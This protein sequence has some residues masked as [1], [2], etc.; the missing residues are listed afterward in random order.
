MSSN[1]F[2]NLKNVNYNLPIKTED[3]TDKIINNK[4]VIDNEHHPSDSLLHNKFNNNNN[5]KTSHFIYRRKRKFKE[6]NSS[7]DTKDTKN[8]KDYKELHSLLNYKKMK[9][10]SKLE[11][12][13]SN[14]KD[15]ENNKIK[16]NN[17]SVDF[18]CEPLKD[19]SLV[20]G[21]VGEANTNTVKFNKFVTDSSFNVKHLIFHE[22]HEN[23]D[24][25]TS[26]NILTLTSGHGHLINNNNNI[27]NNQLKNNDQINGVPNETIKDINYL[28]TTKLTT[29]NKK[30][31]K[32]NA[33]SIK[34]R[35]LKPILYSN[36]NNTKAL[37][38]P[39]T[40]LNN[41]FNKINTS[42]NVTK[43][44]T[45]KPFTNANNLISLKDKENKG[46]E[47]NLNFKKKVVPVNDAKII[48]EFS[49]IFIKPEA[50]ILTNNTNNLK[51][52]NDSDSN[53]ISN[54]IYANNNTISNAI[55]QESAEP[56]EA[57]EQKED[58]TLKLQIKSIIIPE[59]KP[60]NSNNNN[61]NLYTHTTNYNLNN[62]SH[63]Q[64]TNHQTFNETTTRPN[65]NFINANKLL[66]KNFLQSKHNFINKNKAKKNNDDLDNFNIH[67]GFN[68][69]STICNT[70]FKARPVPSYI[71]REVKRSNRDLTIP[72][73]PNITKSKKYQ[74]N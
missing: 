33:T 24:K 30:R 12:S 59:V 46:K 27:I 39:H 55:K 61:N 35:N 41:R 50:N 17:T 69:Y 37:K 70:T 73:S 22:K 52:N 51:I 18:K 56:K 9:V 64:T 1:Q 23:N 7:K 5:D 13:L 6:L 57:H 68:N 42:K 31:I 58:S 8:T 40:K 2:L 71:F 53:G 67:Y 26:K 29:T 60:T 21:T 65:K 36:Y 43:S 63:Q 3:I 62:I 38:T 25:I 15:K 74:K 45:V 54:T 44:A 49:T 11:H 28:Q 10:K 20:V 14:S 16:T 19:N 47:L 66:I 4:M 48:K 32:F 72:I 34:N